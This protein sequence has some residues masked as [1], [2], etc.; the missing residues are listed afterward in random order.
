MVQWKAGAQWLTLFK[1]RECSN[2]MKTI[3][4]HKTSGC[5]YKGSEQSSYLA[6]IRGKGEREGKMA[7]WPF[8]DSIAFNPYYRVLLGTCRLVKSDK[9]GSN[10]TVNLHFYVYINKKGIQVLWS[11]STWRGLCWWLYWLSV[12]V[13][14]FTYSLLIRLLAASSVL[15]EGLYMH[16][17]KCK[18]CMCNNCIYVV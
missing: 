13:E 6:T 5:F 1:M 16:L 11:G 18:V 15:E 8:P 4:I 10:A 17:H 3:N 12:G 14:Q 7:N 2:N 9:S